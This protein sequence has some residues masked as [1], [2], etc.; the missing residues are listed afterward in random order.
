M[1]EI[2][3][4]PDHVLV[5]YD[6]VCALCNGTVNFLLKR[7][8]KDV[9]RFAPL[10]SE[11]GRAVVERHGSDPND[12]DTVYLV[13]NYGQADERVRKRSRAVFKA[14][15]IVGGVWKVFAVFGYI[16]LLPD[17]GY[18]LVARVR[19]R[20]FG[21]KDACPIPPAEHRHKFLAVS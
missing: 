8:R 11:L 6:G 12:L 18:R 13:E 17:L 14:L 5:L 9:F 1:P 16:P 4:Q 10:Q 19:Y 21:K 3:V 15:S 7:D 2:D 20:V